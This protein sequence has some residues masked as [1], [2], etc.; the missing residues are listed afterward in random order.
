[1]KL[2]RALLIVWAGVGCG[3]ASTAVRSTSPEQL[4]VEREVSGWY[5]RWSEALVAGRG[6]LVAESFTPEGLFIGVLPDEVAVGP[7]A[8]VTRAHAPGGGGLASTALTIGVSADA[9]AA[10]ISD[11][12]DAERALR[13]TVVAEKQEGRW[14]ALVAHASRGT[15]PEDARLREEEGRFT[16][17][18]DVGDGVA[19]DAQPLAQIMSQGLGSAEQLAAVISKRPGTMAFGPAPRDRFTGTHE[20]SEW[21]RSLYAREGAR[22]VRNGGMRAGIAAGGDVGWVA[23]NVDLAVSRGAREMARPGRLTAVFAREGKGWA[24]VQ[25]HLS[26]TFPEGG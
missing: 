15:S 17:L 2:L 12:H 20:V 18:T 19:V 22:L 13:I 14:R 7:A 9:Q 25:L 11:V 24:I 26:H 10:W 23:T 5:T 4:A 16:P 3:G 1:M 21:V 8:I 6:S